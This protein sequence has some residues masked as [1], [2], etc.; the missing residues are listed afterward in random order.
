[1]SA[2][3]RPQCY[4]EKK[5]MKWPQICPLPTC[6]P[7]IL[8]CFLIYSI[9]GFISLFFLFFFLTLWWYS[10]NTNWASSI[11][12]LSFH[13]VGHCM[14]SFLGFSAMSN[15]IMIKHRTWLK[16]SLTNKMVAWELCRLAKLAL[17]LKVSCGLGWKISRMFPWSIMCDCKFYP[18]GFFLS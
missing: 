5:M 7:C 9:S 11:C 2:F 15:L 18:K 1:M 14:D 13:E 8:P 12:E 6:T 4:C 16:K 10:F 3:F 17:L